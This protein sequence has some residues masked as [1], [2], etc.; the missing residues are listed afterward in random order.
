MAGFEVPARDLRSRRPR[1]V[2]G[3]TELDNDHWPAACCLDCL[4]VF[5][6][7]KCHEQKGDSPDQTR[8]RGTLVR[9]NESRSSQEG[10]LEE[11]SALLSE[12]VCLQQKPIEAV[13]RNCVFDENP[14][15][16][17]LLRSKRVRVGVIGL[18]Y[19]G[20]PLAMAL[21]ERGLQV[22]GFDIDPEKV[23]AIVNG[24]SY[25]HHISS[26]RLAAIVKHGRPAAPGRLD[27]TIDFDNLAICDVILICVPTPLHEDLT[28]DVSH[29]VHTA[30][31]IAT[32]LRRG[33]LVVLESTTYPGTTDELL[34]PVFEETGLR[35]GTDFHLAFSPEREDPN[36]PEYPVT[37]IPKIVGGVTPQCGHI[38]AQF[39]SLLTERVVLV[40]DARHAEAAK[41]LENTYRAVNIALV[42]EMKVA[43]DKMGINIWEVIE[44]AS[45]KPFGFCRFTP[46][47]GVGGHCIPIDPLYLSWRTTQAGVPLR[48]IEVAASIN[49]GMPEFV[50]RK[51]RSALEA[52]TKPLRGSRILILGAAYKPGL[53]D[54]RESPSLELME[55]LLSEG[56]AVSYHDPY[57]PV[58][59]R[60]RH[61]DLS[62]R[63][64]ELDRTTLSRND[65]VVIMT[66][67]GF[68]YD[69]VVRHSQLVVDTRNATKDVRDGSRIVSA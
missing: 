22:V 60:S 46:G 59:K 42:N 45:T 61:H 67:H 69:F 49:R 12:T 38:A 48:L 27:V 40:S 10:T 9:D 13:G 43:F 24:R 21:A 37:E 62:L 52:Q 66:D 50:C 53:D 1:G 19:V 17:G 16:W 35:A 58:L 44:A 41:L 26:T 11:K 23:E 36:N 31:V 51:L 64:V 55:M 5:S 32:H 28:P 54:T 29:I 15:L 18:G 30:G 3:F 57:V 33:Q 2:P 47:P 25:I 8:G 14:V 63:S 39:Y 56:A 34:R 68:D 6:A 65:A 20:L 7:V 4:Y